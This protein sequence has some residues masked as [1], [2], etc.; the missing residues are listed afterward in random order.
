MPGTPDATAYAI[1]TGTNMV[2]NTRP[3]AMSCRSQATS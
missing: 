3:A 2:V 1:P